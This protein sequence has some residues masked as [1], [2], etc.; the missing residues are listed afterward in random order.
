MS[1]R[2]SF[3]LLSLAFTCAAVIIISRPDFV[4]SDELAGTIAKA[5]Q[6]L[7]YRNC[8]TLRQ[9]LDLMT[10][11]YRKA[12]RQLGALSCKVNGVGPTGGFCLL[13]P[14]A[15]ID[16]TG[17]GGNSQKCNSVAEALRRHFAGQSVYDFGAGLGWHGQYG[18]VLTRNSTDIDLAPALYTAYDAAANVEEVTDGV[19]TWLD[20]TSRVDLGPRDWVLG[21][22]VGEHIHAEHED[23]FI[24]NL[25]RHNTRGIV[26][27]WATEGEAGRFHVNPR[28][29]EYIKS[30]FAALGYAND[31]E[32]ENEL[33]QGASPSCFKNTIMVFKRQK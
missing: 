28:S 4:D 6:I 19:V 18:Q 24:L 11:Q 1:T 13:Q 26:L 32:L 10:G 29:N 22:E 5:G 3:L 27:S 33:R 14:D 25:H 21:I 2:N 23:T 12:T 17:V 8:D 9:E 30:K 16:T 20:L 31:L 15:V 7:S